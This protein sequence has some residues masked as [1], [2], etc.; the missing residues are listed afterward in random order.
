MNSS[1][2]S[3]KAVFDYL[4]QRARM[5]VISFLRG[6]DLQTNRLKSLQITAL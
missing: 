6:K 1:G 4:E 2:P 5:W 3:R